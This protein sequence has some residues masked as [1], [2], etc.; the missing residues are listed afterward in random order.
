MT[1]TIMIQESAH[2]QLL[3]CQLRCGG[4]CGLLEGPQGVV[5]QD[6]RTFQG[7]CKEGVSLGAVCQE[8]QAV[9]EGVQ[10]LD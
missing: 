2:N 1:I 3:S 7:Q 10:E 6:L 5:R 9:C 4:Y 8:S